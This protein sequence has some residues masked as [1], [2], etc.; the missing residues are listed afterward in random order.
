MTPDRLQGLP[1]RLVIFDCDGV[2]VDSEGP[3][4]RIVAEEITNLGWPMTEAES[5]TLFMGSSLSTMP[6][7]IEAKLG[8][9][10]PEGWVEMLRNRLIA[11]FDVVPTIPGARAALQ[12]VTALGLPFRVA[13]NSSHEE[14]DAKFQHTGL[15][16]LI[17]RR[18]HSARDVPYGK[19]APDVFLQAAQAEGIPPS[20][21]I[22]IEDSLPGITA[23]RAAGMRVIGLETH[24]NT[25]MLRNAGAHPIA[26]L[27]DLPAL[28]RTLT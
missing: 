9:V 28:L 20:A 19:P 11:A 27:G 1:V 12:A 7:V 22:V 10:V 14:M 4:N 26:T 24:G 5:T 16:A 2:L 3:A 8:Q 21:C 15:A 18:Q 17:R 13:S 25:D 23:A 6:A